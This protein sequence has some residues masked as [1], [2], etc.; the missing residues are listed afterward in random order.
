MNSFVRPART[1]L[2]SVSYAY[3]LLQVMAT[4]GASVEAIIH[5]SG[6]PPL[7]LTGH[8]TRLSLEQFGQLVQACARHGDVAGLGYAFGLNVKPPSHGLL[9]LAMLNARTAREAME[10]A[11]RFSRLRSGQ[12]QLCLAEDGDMTALQVE[13]SEMVRLPLREFFHEALA[14]VLWRFAQSLALGPQPCEIWFTH[15]EPAHHR[16]WRAHLP[17][18]R[19][20]MPANQLRLPSVVLDAPL[21]SPNP[22]SAHAAVTQMEAQLELV[23]ATSD[24]TC[25]VRRLL[26][27]SREALPALAEVAAQ[28]SISPSTLKRRLQKEGASF[29]ALLDATRRQ[30]ALALLQQPAL[31]IEQVG[32]RLGYS[33][34][35]NFTR[36]FRKWTGASPTE[37]RNTR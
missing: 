26:Q 19:F 27:A 13:G 32:R 37:W 3:D 1:A 6:V 21:P 31:T 30:R 15:A 35:A 33:D 18:V 29:Q 7:L 12:L 14:G 9:G 11:V 34:V 2:V 23:G 24:M 20:G 28:L 17:A 5:D 4:R 22:V 10:M 8:D 25:Q 36:A 16:H